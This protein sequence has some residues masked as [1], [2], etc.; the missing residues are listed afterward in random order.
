MEL[1]KVDTGGHGTVYGKTYATVRYKVAARLL[2]GAHLG[3]GNDG[4]GERGAEQIAALVD[5]V[6]LDGAEAELLDELALQVL[7]DHVGGANGL[8]LGPDRVPVLLL[9]DVGKEADDLVALLC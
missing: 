2:G 4:A 7:N 1:D 6:A 8:G 5:G 9:A 3:A